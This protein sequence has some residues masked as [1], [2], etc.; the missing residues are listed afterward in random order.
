MSIGKRRT[1]PDRRKTTTNL[2]VALP[3]IPRA[4]TGSRNPP[5]WGATEIKLRARGATGT[6]QSRIQE[7]AGEPHPEWNGTRPE[8][9][10]FWALGKLGKKP[11]DDFVYRP[12]LTTG[13]TSS[14]ESEV[15]FLIPDYNI[16]IEI[17]GRF[18][19][20][21]QGSR[22]VI[23]DIMRVASFALMGIKIIFIDEPDALSDPIHFTKEA[24]EGNDLSH[25]N[26][27]RQATQM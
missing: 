9:A 22:K 2:N 12:K 15:D 11:G 4:N 8:W 13:W 16:A 18:W 19:H 27:I 17:Q 25:V 1:S 3:K 14:G 24:L 7:P 23:N 21:G 26:R 5:G 6:N 20:Y 10:V